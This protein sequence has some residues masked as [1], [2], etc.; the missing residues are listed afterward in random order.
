MTMFSIFDGRASFW[1]WDLNQRLIVS[2]DSC[3]EVHF[4]NGT[5][6]HALVCEVKEKDGYRISE[7]PNILLQSDKLHPREYRTLP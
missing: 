4:D 5:T 7:V 1:Q 3:C 6:E 2:D